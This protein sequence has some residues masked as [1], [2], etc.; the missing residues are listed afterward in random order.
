M[1]KL[2]EEFKNCIGH[3][4]LSTEI[5]SLFIRHYSPQISIKRYDLGP[6]L[7]QLTMIHGKIAFSEQLFVVA[8]TKRLAFKLA[9]NLSC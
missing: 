4:Q 7:P 5:E 6:V 2:R 1:L 8:M 9:A 3:I